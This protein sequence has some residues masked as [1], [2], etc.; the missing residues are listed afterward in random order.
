L[1]SIFIFTASVLFGGAEF[2]GKLVVKCDTDDVLPVYI[3]GIYVGKTPLTI[4]E[5]PVGTYL[6]SFMAPLVRDSILR[7]KKGDLPPG[8]QKLFGGVEAVT[9]AKLSTINAMVKDRQATEAVFLIKEVVGAVDES[10]RGQIVKIATLCGVLV[11]IFT[12]LA[13]QAL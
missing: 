13:L 2:T 5:Q 12:A 1:I 6:I 10:K 7:S 9:V 11:L 8:Y 3:D 4:E